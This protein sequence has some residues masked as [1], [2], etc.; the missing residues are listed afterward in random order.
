[1]SD[2][3]I[4]VVVL[5]GIFVLRILAATLVIFWILP[6]GVR[7]PV[8]DAI[9]VHVQSRVLERVMPWYRNS[10]CLGC[11]WEGLLKRELLAVSPQAMARRRSQSGQLP[12]SSK[13]SSK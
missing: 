10:W 11:G 1:M 8:C 7:C 3:V 5:G 13:K 12:L 9:T 6:S 4:F 2:A